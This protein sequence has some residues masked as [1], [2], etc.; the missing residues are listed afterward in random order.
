M[1]S[2]TDPSITFSS[3]A[4][5][6]FADRVNNMQGW[7]VRLTTQEGEHIEAQIL[8]TDQ[9]TEIDGTTWY[10]AVRYLD[11]GEDGLPLAGA[12]PKTVRVSDV[13]VY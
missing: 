9:D 1:T 10:D 5:E 2:D 3:E 11:V 6:G 8:G 13:Y 12:E 4:S 7:Y